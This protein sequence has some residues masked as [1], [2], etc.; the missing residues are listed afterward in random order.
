MREL[1]KECLKQLNSLDVHNDLTKRIE[2][3]PPQPAADEQAPAI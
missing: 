1:L 3:N 2:A